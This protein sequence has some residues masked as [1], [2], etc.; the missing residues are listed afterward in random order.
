MSSK[1][2]DVQKQVKKVTFVMQD[3]ASKGS[4]QFKR[5][6]NKVDKIVWWKNM[7]LLITFILL[8]GLLGVLVY[9]FIKIGQEPI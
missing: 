7:K 9:L 8:I 2:N 3:N 1:P 4:K 5:D 6:A